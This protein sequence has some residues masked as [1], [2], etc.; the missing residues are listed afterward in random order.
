MACCNSNDFQ[1][2]KTPAHLAAENGHLPCLELL[3]KRGARVD[4]VDNVRIS[5]NNE[6]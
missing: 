5:N 2:N 1:R 6:I 3:F 4:A